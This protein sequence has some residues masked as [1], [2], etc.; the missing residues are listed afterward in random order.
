[1]EIIKRTSETEKQTV[2]TKGYN[3][4]MQVSFNNFG[5]IALRFFDSEFEP[6]PVKWKSNCK[7]CHKPIHTTKDAYP[8]WYHDESD[9]GDCDMK[10]DK[11]KVIVYA[12]PN[13]EIPMTKPQE[14]LVVLDAAESRDLIQFIKER[15]Q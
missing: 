7:H 1:M 14:T 15:L 6:L 11:V 10:N 2:S 5:H 13:E 4:K 8:F 12:T 9:S 3:E